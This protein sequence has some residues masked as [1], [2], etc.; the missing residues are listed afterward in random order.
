MGKRSYLKVG[1]IIKAG[2]VLFN[3]IAIKRIGTASEVEVIGTADG[4][5]FGYMI[6]PGQRVEPLPGYAL[7]IDRITENGRIEFEAFAPFEHIHV[8]TKQKQART[9][10]V[11]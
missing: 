5:P 9:A 4:Q 6:Q 7:R 2:P 11:Q 10:G 1:G 3:A 8:Q